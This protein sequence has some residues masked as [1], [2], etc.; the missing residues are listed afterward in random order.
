MTVSKS[1]CSR[2]SIYLLTENVPVQ[3]PSD[4]ELRDAMADLPMPPGLDA[5]QVHRMLDV[6]KRLYAMAAIRPGRFA[7]DIVLLA[8]AD[9]GMRRSPIGGGRTCPEISLSA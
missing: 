4:E 3:L 1:A 9:E 5:E 7:G 6:W 2:C 8:A